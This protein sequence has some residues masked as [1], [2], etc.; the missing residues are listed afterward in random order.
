MEK[1]Q[2]SGTD[3]IR[4]IEQ[5][6]GRA[7]EEEIDNGMGWV[8]WGWMLFL[9][10]IINYVMFMMDAPNKFIIWSIF[11]I[12]AVVFAIYSVFVRPFFFPREPKSKHIPMNW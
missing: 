10:S 12:V 11:G 5:M 9:A 8:I 4:I 1:D 3:S 7:K 6:I 2:L